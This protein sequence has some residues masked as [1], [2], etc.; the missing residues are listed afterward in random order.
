MIIWRSHAIDGFKSNV[1]KTFW[2]YG[3]HMYKPIHPYNMEV[4]KKI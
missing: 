1:A 2:I 4:E 3:K